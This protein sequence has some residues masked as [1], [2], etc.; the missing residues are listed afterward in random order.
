[1][2]KVQIK[3]IVILAI[4]FAVT[5]CGKDWLDVKPKGTLLEDNFYQNADDAF[6]GLVAIYDQVG[7]TSGGYI[8]KFTATLA[9]SD[10]HFAGGGSATDVNNLQVGH[11]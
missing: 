8:N 7:G 11:F 10:D 6:E 5:S 1:M 9:A 3:Y 2:K 4:A